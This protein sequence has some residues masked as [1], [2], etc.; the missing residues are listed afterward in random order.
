[1]AAEAR[2]IES[3]FEKASHLVA[4]AVKANSAGPVIRALAAEGC[5]A[6]VVSGPELVLANKCGIPVDKIIYSGVAKSD[7]ELDLAL[8]LDGQ[9]IRAINVESVEEIQRLAARARAKNQVARVT[10][11]INPGVDEDVIDTHKHIT[12]GH[13]DAKFG[14]P[15]ST[16]NAAVEVLLA[17]AAHVKLTAIESYLSSARKVFE[18]AKSLRPKFALE[19]VDTGGGFGIDYGKGC[20]VKPADFIREARRTRKMLGGGMRQGGILAAAG[21]YAFEHNIARLAD[22]HANARLLAAGLAELG[23]FE[24]NVPQTNIVV[25][26]VRR[27]SLEQ[28]VGAF[29]EQGVLAVP[30]GRGRM[31]MVTHLNITREDIEEALRRVRRAVEAVAV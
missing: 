22:D 17:N 14:I 15:L 12:T 19:L 4:Y 16:L 28:W 10:L 21:L 27:G 8:G 18:I 2:A 23:V 26:N 24:P 1:M 20:P 30:F 31:R 7:D 13:D 3:A 6:D 5:G 25:A 29:R 9:G 11:R